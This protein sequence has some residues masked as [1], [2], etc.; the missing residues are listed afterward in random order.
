MKIT[1]KEAVDSFC[2]Q[3]NWMADETLTR[4]RKVE[5]EEYFDTQDIDKR[6]RPLLCCYLC[7][8]AHGLTKYNPDMVVCS[9]CPINWGGKIGNCC[10]KDAKDDNKGL[11]EKWDKS[12]DDYIEAATLAREIANLP[13]KEQ[14]REEYEN[15]IG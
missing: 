8:Y 15:A 11:Y 4:K 9:N 2:K 7:E 3:W 6:D 10:S 12:T 1:L 5:K 13:L 14:Y